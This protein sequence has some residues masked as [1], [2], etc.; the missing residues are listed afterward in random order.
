MKIDDPMSW[1]DTKGGMH[2]VFV[3]T[4]AIDVS[5]NRLLLVV[6]DINANFSGLEGYRTSKCELVFEA[7]RSIFLDLEL[8]EGLAFSDVKIIESG[9]GYRFEAVLRYG[10]G[11]LADKCPSLTFS[12]VTLDVFER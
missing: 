8:H 10:G 1:V 6:E 7:V 12:F 2:D 3:E 5:N 9:N 11:L 4:L